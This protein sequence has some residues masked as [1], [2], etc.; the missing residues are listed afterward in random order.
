MTAVVNAPLQTRPA[1]YDSDNDGMPNDWEERHGLNPNSPAGSPD[2]ILDYDNDGYVN[3]EEYINEV[4][5]WPAPYD[6]VFTGGANARYEQITNWSI[7]RS[8]PGEADTTTHWQPSRFD[9]AVIN[10]GSVTVDSV[11]QHAGLLTIAHAAGSI[12]EL[13]ITDGWLRATEAVV[14]TAVLATPN[15][16]HP[17]DVSACERSGMGY[18]NLL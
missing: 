7:T 4:A 14:I 3:V 18:R 15:P 2:W 11:G 8:S 13:R 1:G 17:G 16:S 10:N 6:I 5:E 12:A 9:V